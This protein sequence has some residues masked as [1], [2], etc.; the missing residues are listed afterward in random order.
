[1]PTFREKMERVIEIVRA[2]HPTQLPDGLPPRCNR[3]R[4]FDFRRRWKREVV[5]HLADADVQWLLHRGMELCDPHYRPGDCA[6]HFGGIDGTRIVEGKLSWYRPL[7]RCHWIA[8]FVWG[9]ASKIY[10]NDEWYVVCGYFHAV[11]TNRD[12]SFVWDILL[13]RDHTARESLVMAGDSPRAPGEASF[14][15]SLLLPHAERLTRESP[16]D[17]QLASLVTSLSGV[18]VA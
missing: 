15:A 18:A 12:A 13:G 1:M 16:D 10:P 9:L 6:A 2:D 8:P 17:P 5:P 7:G 14:L 11:V 3:P 4:Q